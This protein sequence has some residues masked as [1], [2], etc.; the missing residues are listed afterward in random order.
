LDIP[1]ISL[2]KGSGVES[3]V[4]N[5][6]GVGGDAKESFQVPD[7]STRSFSFFFSSESRNMELV[8]IID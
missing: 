5:L 7:D 2:A 1:L 4:S 8:E 6:G 3:F